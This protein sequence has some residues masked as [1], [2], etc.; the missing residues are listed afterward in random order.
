MPLCVFVLCVWCVCVVCGVCRLECTVLLEPEIYHRQSFMMRCLHIIL[1]ISIWD[2]KLNTSIHKAATG[3][4]ECPHSYTS[5]RRLR[6][7]GHLVCM[8]DN[9]FP[10]KMLVSSLPT[11]KRS[12]SGQ[13]C[14]WNDLLLKDLRKIGFL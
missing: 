5:Q 8:S 4:N 9:R 10:R 3:S 14:R 7:A 6:F 12:V 1:S 11:G 2:N 13:K